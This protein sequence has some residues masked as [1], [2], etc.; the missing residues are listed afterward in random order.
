QSGRSPTLVNGELGELRVL[1]RGE[2]LD[3]VRPA[4]VPERDPG[5]RGEVPARVRRQVDRPPVGGEP[6]I[7]EATGPLVR[8]EAHLLAAGSLDEEEVLVAP[9]GLAVQDG[10]TAVAADVGETTDASRLG[11]K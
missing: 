7:R 5:E 8:R 1:P 10:A 3:R 6:A 4:V 11:S 9:A 2:H